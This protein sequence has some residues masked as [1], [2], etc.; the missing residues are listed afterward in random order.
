M[1]VWRSP[2]L[3]HWESLGKPFD[4]DNGYWARQEPDRFEGSRDDW[5][6]W[7]PEM[8]FINGAGTWCTRRPPRVRGGANIAVTEGDDSR[9]RHDPS[10]FQDDNGTVYLLWGNTVIVSLKPDMSGFASEPTRIEP[11]SER[12]RL[13]DNAR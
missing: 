11:S 12:P 3:F 10:L 2:D 5:R 4:L 6:L 9:S 8:H 1:C 7:A 13:N